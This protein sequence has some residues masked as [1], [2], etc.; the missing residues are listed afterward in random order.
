[1]A[2]KLINRIADKFRKMNEENKNN[3][4]DENTTNTNPLADEQPATDEQQPAD[5]IAEPATDD[6]EAKYNEAND[7]YLRLYSEFDNFRRR[8]ARERIDLV[9]TAGSDVIKALLPVVDDFERALKNLEDNAENAA[10]REG[11]LLIYNKM[12]HTLQGKGLEEMKTLGEAF[13]AD[14]HEAL[15]QIP[16][17]SDDLKGKVVDELE[18]GYYLH[19]KVIRYAKVV[20]GS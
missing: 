7:K 5:N 11:I 9:A 16:A 17:P 13:D 4:T 14:L 1:M 8:S 2:K 10:T 6:W 12:K 18:K 3:V 15:T 20:V 19:G